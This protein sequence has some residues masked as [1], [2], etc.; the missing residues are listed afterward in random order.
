MEYDD[1]DPEPRWQELDIW[2]WLN[3]SAEWGLWYVRL[4]GFKERKLDMPIRCD[5][6]LCMNLATARSKFVDPRRSHDVCTEYVVKFF[7]SQECELAICDELERQA[8]IARCV[9]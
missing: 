3:R 4:L 7:C 2:F 5:N 6:P 1:D 9:Q 8:N